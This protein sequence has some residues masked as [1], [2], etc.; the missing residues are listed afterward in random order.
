MSLRKI[1]FGVLI[2]ATIPVALYLI[3]AANYVNRCSPARV[4]CLEHRKAGCSMDGEYDIKIGGVSSE[5]TCDM[6]TEGGGWTLVANYLHR[7]IGTSKAVPKLMDRAKLPLANQTLLGGDER[8]TGNWGHVSNETLAAIPF[9]ELRFRCQSSAHD[10]LVDF[11]LNGER[12][13]NYF[14]TGRGSCMDGS[15]EAKQEVLTSSRA[16]ANSSGRLPKA[17]DKGWKDQGDFALTNYPFFLDY[18][19]HWSIGAADNRF[20]CDD[21]ESGGKT[22]T[23]HQIWIR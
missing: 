11:S 15:P 3:S 2:V 6:H 7:G 14:R 9:K 16:L 8:G 22:N 13:L 23:W 10:R 18:R 20:E 19:H 4:S 5:V 21:Y 1:F 17:A 12:C